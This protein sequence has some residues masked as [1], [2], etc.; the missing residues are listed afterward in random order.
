[1][2]AAVEVDDQPVLE[3]GDGDRLDVVGH[4]NA[5]PARTAAA[6]ATR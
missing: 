1:M 6:C 3:D 4:T 5:R 2:Q